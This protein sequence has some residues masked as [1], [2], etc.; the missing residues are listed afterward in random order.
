[1]TVQEHMLAE[2]PG[3]ELQVVDAKLG[4]RENEEDPIQ[5]FEY[6]AADRNCSV[7]LAGVY[8]SKLVFDKRDQGCQ[9][10]KVSH[11]TMD[12]EASDFCCQFL[13]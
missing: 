13:K 4:S 7:V 11:M 1:M 8:M 6:K 10:K 3:C 9:Q 5:Q 2:T 12:Q